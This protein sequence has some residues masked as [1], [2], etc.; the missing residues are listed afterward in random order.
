MTHEHEIPTVSIVQPRACLWITGVGALLAILVLRHVW[1]VISWGHYRVLAL[2]I[3][4]GRWLP[5]SVPRIAATAE[6]LASGYDYGPA[7]GPGAGGFHR[8]QGF[9]PQVAGTGPC[10]SAGVR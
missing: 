9:P 8:P 5:R 10:W 7:G 2:I 4:T 6:I 1:F 3:H